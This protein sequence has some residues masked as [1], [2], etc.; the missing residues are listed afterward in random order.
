[1]GLT[2]DKGTVRTTQ[3]VCKEETVAVDRNTGTFRTTET[4]YKEEE[5]VG[6]D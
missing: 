4:F 6:W 1:M 5:R 2:E 3:V